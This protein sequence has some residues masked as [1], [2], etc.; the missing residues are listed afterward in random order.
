M[1]SIYYISGSVSEYP[2]LSSDKVIRIYN[3]TTGV[4]IGQVV[5]NNGVYYFEAEADGDEWNIVCLDNTG[6]Y[7][8]L[9]LRKTPIL[10]VG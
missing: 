3:R 10:K 8:D 4:L 5:S 2:S 9:I 1:A 7:K 6:K